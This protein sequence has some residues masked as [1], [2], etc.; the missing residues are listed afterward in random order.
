M[1]TEVGEAVALNDVLGKEQV[2]E[3]LRIV[4]LLHVKVAQAEDAFQT[5]FLL[6]TRHGEVVGVRHTA[7][8]L[9]RLVILHPG[10]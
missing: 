7:V 3:G 10:G 5:E 9:Y 1:H 8:K 6:G 4:S 2:L